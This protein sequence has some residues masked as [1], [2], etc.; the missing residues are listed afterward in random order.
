MYETACLECFDAEGEP[1][2]RYIGETARSGSE[3]FGEHMEDVE[4]EKK[5]SHIYTGHST[6][7][8]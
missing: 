7:V 5:D 3:R 8:G 2:A 6:I 1:R 4:K